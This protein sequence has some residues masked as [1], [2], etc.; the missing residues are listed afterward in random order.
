MAKFIRVYL[1]VFLF[2]AFPVAA[3]Q[4][5]QTSAGAQTKSGDSV[6]RAQKRFAIGEI[7]RIVA[8]VVKESYPELQ[9]TKIKVKTFESK[10]DYFRS[11]FSVTRF[12]TFRKLRCVILINPHVYEKNA[13]ADG[14][15]AIIAHELAHTAYY[16]RHNRFE[17]F[18]LIG[19]ES[20]AFTARFERGADLQAIKRGYGAGLKNYRE[21]L[22]RNIPPAKMPA[23]KRDYFSPEEIDLILAAIKEK[24][25]LMNFWIKK[26][27]RSADEIR[28]S[29]KSFS[30]DEK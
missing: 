16:K 13:P 12:L 2:A 3:Q 5:S 27:P 14:I 10:S 23:K 29:A 30:Q 9:N 21:W 25:A 20:K 22:Y 11:Q 15:R 8:E 6:F 7:S 24:P 17:L 18:G 26:V 1:F 4:T 19:L 28:A